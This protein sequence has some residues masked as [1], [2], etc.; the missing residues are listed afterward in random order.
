VIKAAEYFALH[1]NATDEYPFQLITG[2]TIY[3]F[4]TCTKTARTPELQ[5]AAPD[6]WAEVSAQDADA[7]GVR[8]GEPVDVVS[9]RGRLPGRPAGG[10][11]APRLGIRPVPLRVLGYGGE[12]GQWTASPGV[13]RTS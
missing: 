7:L 13:P 3:H 11:P 2:R 10:G 1:E 6:V 12:P 9:P 5:A 4:H 8:D